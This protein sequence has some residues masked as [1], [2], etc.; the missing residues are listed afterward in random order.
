MRRTHRLPVYLTRWISLISCAVLLV[1]S[2]GL[3]PSKNS[4]VRRPQTQETGSARARKAPPKPP[5]PGAPALNLPNLDEAR[6]RT[7][8]PPRVARAIESTTRSRRKPLEPRQG[9][10]VGDPIPRATPSPS[11]SPTPRQS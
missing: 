4:S 11:P 3:A 9:R 8:T 5:E 10:K 1:S 7:N 2:L 6:Q